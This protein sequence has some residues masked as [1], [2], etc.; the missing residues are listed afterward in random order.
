MLVISPTTL[1]IQKCQDEDGNWHYGDVAVT[2]CENSKVTTLNDRGFITEELQAPKSAEEIEQQE[3]QI[4]VDLAEQVRLKQEQEERI[5][6]LSIYETEADIDRQRENQLS[7]V[8]SNIAVHES[9]LKSMATRIE[10]LDRQKEATKIVPRKEQYQVDIEQANARVEKSKQ[11]LAL[12]QEQKADIIE[13][14]EKEKEIYLRLK[15]E[16]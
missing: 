15:N 1:A 11:E 6:V 10:R 4:A 9:Y 3:Q 5:R 7:S 12:L 2:E 13:K 14:F 8:Q 16:D